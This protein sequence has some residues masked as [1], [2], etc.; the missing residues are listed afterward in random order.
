MENIYVKFGS[1]IFSNVLNL[2][3][4]RQM[5]ADLGN[6]EKERPCSSCRNE[7]PR[8]KCSE[9]P[10]KIKNPGCSYCSFWK[11]KPG[12][13]KTKS[14]NHC[15]ELKTINKFYRNKANPDGLQGKCIKC[16]LIYGTE[17]QRNNKKLREYM[18]V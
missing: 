11:E 6:T 4:S 1:N 7:L 9:I 15:G 13:L 5:Y 14:C 8:N 17:Y 16:A 12:K 3:G 2:K 10:G 18:G